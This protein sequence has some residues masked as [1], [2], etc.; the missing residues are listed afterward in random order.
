M[1][2]FTKDLHIFVIGVYSSPQLH[3]RMCPS[4]A[5]EVKQPGQK[6]FL[7]MEEVVEKYFGT[8]P[9]YSYH[10]QSVSVTDLLSAPDAVCLVTSLC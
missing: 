2:C 4:A 5:P 9:S 1:N 7:R 3:H 8:S 6:K 10:C